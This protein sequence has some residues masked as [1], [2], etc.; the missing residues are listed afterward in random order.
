MFVAIEEGQK[1]IAHS[2]CT[3]LPN[4]TKMID[5]LVSTTKDLEKYRSSVSYKTIV[6]P[7]MQPKKVEKKAVKNQ[8]TGGAK[9]HKKNIFP[10]KE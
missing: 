8:P 9:H 7:A 5:Y 10:P 1:V 4:N 3:R 2:I 6:L